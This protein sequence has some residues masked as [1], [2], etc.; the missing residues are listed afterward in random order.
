MRKSGYGYSHLFS[1][2]HS[3][4]CPSRSCHPSKLRFSFPLPPLS[5][6]SG[7]LVSCGHE[8]GT[9]KPLG[10]LPVEVSCD[11]IRIREQARL[12]VTAPSKTTSRQIRQMLVQENSEPTSTWPL[13]SG[14]KEA[15]SSVSLLL[16]SPLSWRFRLTHRSQGVAS[17]PSQEFFSPKPDEEK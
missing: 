2:P 10:H 12:P 17:E 14:Q 16:P 8:S 5:Q 11:F 4:L 15:D 7:Q 3:P 13:P 6:E 9:E 1:E